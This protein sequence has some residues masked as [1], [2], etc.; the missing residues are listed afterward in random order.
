MK[1][2]F[3]ELD[4][5]WS[6]D[7]YKRFQSLALVHVNSNAELRIMDYCGPH[8][9]DEVDMSTLSDAEHTLGR[10]PG[11]E[12]LDPGVWVWEGCIYGQ[13]YETLEGTDYDIAV[14]GVWREPTD[15]EWAALRT[16][17]HL[18]NR[19]CLPVLAQT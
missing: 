2:E 11:V 10:C 18:W 9:E 3:H 4:T 6:K 1:I 17:Q 19:D 14:K 12:E 13:K 8:I 7:D 16:K 15:Q 5:P